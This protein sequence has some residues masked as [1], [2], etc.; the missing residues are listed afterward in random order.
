MHLFSSEQGQLVIFYQH[1]YETSGVVKGSEF[2]SFIKYSFVFTRK[3][4][5]FCNSSCQILRIKI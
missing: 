4:H 5:K 3:I 1:D 2:D